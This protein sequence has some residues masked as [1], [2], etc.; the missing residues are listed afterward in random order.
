MRSPNIMTSIS[1]EIDKYTFAWDQEQYRKA[2]HGLVFYGQYRHLFPDKIV[3]AIDYGCGTGRLLKRMICD[4]IDARGV[5]FAFNAVDADILA[6]HFARIDYANLC[7]YD[8]GRRFHVGICAD[9]MEHIPD[10]DISGVLENVSRH[11]D[12]VYFLIANYPSQ[13]DGRV[14][15]V[16][17]HDSVWWMETIGQY[18]DVEL[19]N[20]KR[21]ARDAFA[22]RLIPGE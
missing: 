14:F 3:S 17:L 7:D 5:D 6:E 9:V 1:P 8:P 12:M 19:L 22:I 2:C 11:C 10:D 15:H 4:G 16:S 21:D 18:G 20:Y 13:M